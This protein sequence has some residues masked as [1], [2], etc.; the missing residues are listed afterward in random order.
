MVGGEI[1]L[2]ATSLQSVA[3]LGPC[4]LLPDHSDTVCQTALTH[5]GPVLTSF[6]AIAPATGPL[7]CRSWD[8]INLLH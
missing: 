6:L 3:M 8:C 7:D 2:A 1:S 5:S 4:G